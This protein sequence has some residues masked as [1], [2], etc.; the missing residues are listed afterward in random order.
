[1]LNRNLRIFCFCAGDPLDQLVLVLALAYRIVEFVLR[2]YLETPLHLVHVT[3]FLSVF[4]QVGHHF[5]KD[6]LDFL[7]R[8]A[9]AILALGV[10]LVLVQFYLNKNE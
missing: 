5:L 3:L 8:N 1:M 2:D 9:L 4:G 6:F 7:G 10:T